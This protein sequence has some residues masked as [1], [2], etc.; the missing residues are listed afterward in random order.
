MGEIIEA[1]TD[2]V[3]LG[4]NQS[5]NSGEENEIDQAKRVYFSLLPVMGS[6]VAHRQAKIR[7][8][9]SVLSPVIW[10]ASESWTLAKNSKQALNAFKRKVPRRILGPMKENNT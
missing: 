1:V 3:Y 9:K 7:L 6:R 10:Y 4:S 2:F 5:T 8:N